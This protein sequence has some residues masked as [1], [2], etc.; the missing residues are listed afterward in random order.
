M[1][2]KIFYPAAAVVAVLLIAFSLVWPQGQG[3]V[4]PPPFGHKIELPDYFRM[5]RERGIRQAK[6]AERKADEAKRQSAA[7]S[8]ASASSSA[9]AAAATSHR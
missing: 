9:V 5:V 6:E 7:Q 2:D 4:S 8:S 3:M 1:P